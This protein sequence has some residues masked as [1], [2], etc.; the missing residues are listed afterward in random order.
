MRSAGAFTRL[1]VCLIAISFASIAAAPATEPDFGP[2]NG[3]W[4]GSLGPVNG[5]GL[6]RSD[7]PLPVRLTIQGSTARVFV[8][9]G[10]GDEVKPG[11]FVVQRLMTNLVVYAMDSD[12]DDD[13][14]WVES[15]VFALTQ[16]DRNTLIANFYRVV[17]NLNVPLSNTQ[18][19]FSVGMT[20]E[21]RR[22]SR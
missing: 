18:S 21:L 5:G 8:G 6:A 1:L 15:W 2:V 13:G 14:T 19:K 20:G 11:N 17:N 12:S 9:A 10:F 22:S 3:V 16:K 4:E 7:K